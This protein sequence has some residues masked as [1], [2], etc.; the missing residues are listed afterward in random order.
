MTTNVFVI[1]PETNFLLLKNLDVICVHT[2]NYINLSKFDELK[3][4]CKLEKNDFQ[5][6][7]LHQCFYLSVCL[8]VYLSICLY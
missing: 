2:K 6:A 4:F 5:I 8:S 3:L 7:D 1:I